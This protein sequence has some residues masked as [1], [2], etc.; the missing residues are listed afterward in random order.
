MDQARLPYGKQLSPKQI[1]LR[2]LLTLLRD[3]EG[4]AKA[5]HAAIGRLFFPKPSDSENEIK[6]GMNAFLA[7][8]SHGLVTD[9]TPF[10]LTPVGKSLITTKTDEELNAAFAKHLLLKHHGIQML[11]VIESLQARGEEVNGAAI[12][13][14]LTAVGIDPGGSS[15]E[16]LN[17]MRLW[18]ERAGVL[19][20]TWTIDS[21]VLKRLIGAA[22][23]E[24]S[25]LVAL[26]LAQQAFL[27]AIATVTDPPPLDGAKLR[28]LAELQTPGIVIPLKTHAPITLKR[29]EAGGWITV[30]KTT[31]GRGAK[32]HQVVP[33]QRFK[34]IIAEPLMNAVVEQVHL[35]DPAPLRKPIPDLLAVVHDE[36]RSNYE[37]GL[38]L[39]G[40]CIQ[41]ARLAGARFL[42]WR[43]RGA[44][45]G[46]AEVD[47]VA[48]SIQ[49]PYQII[50]VQSKASAINGRQIVDREVGVSAA[51][52]SNII[53]FVSAKR[54]GAAARK[55]AAAH[56]QESS[57]SILFLDSDDLKGVSAGAGLGAALGREWERVRIVR[58]RRGQERAK[59]LGE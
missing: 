39:E 21:A 20:D 33:T 1:N 59:T 58:S 45:T 32:P 47:V 24:I 6:S 40:I 10:A 12:V 3:I 42:S 48:E 53:L 41:V 29:L 27:R 30:T 18:L 5:A 17:P 56:M 22:P 36:A 51:L 13:R 15:G 54:I 38:A 35:Q 14:E 31:G 23:D 28:E 16:N 7:V 55:A 8:R 34:E 37:R 46:G 19:I 11:E 52:K 4:D 57:L 50:Q 49:P 9:S 43:L 26:P 2:E 25:E 44:E